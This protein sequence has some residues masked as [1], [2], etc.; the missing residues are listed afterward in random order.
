[1]QPGAAKAAQGE[2]DN[3]ETRDER[4][5]EGERARSRAGR[6]KAKRE[7]ARAH[8]GERAREKDAELEGEREASVHRQSFM[9]ARS[10][11]DVNMVV[12][13]PPPAIGISLALAV[14]RRRQE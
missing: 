13:T 3:G 5:G 7:D 14:L 11:L 8:A 9:Q 6:S 4:K 1:M 2:R 12:I 10:V